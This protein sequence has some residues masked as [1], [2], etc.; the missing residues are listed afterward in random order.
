MSDED[1]LLRLWALIL[2]IVGEPS[3][4]DRRW[5]RR[6]ARRRG[7]VGA[8]QHWLRRFAALEA[9]AATNEEGDDTLSHFV[10]DWFGVS[11]DSPHPDRRD[12]LRVLMVALTLHFTER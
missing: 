4:R 5:A 1:I 12:L 3:E 10:R 11:E 9:L 8:W 2:P 7:W 6:I